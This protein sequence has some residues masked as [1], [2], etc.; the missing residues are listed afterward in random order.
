[1]KSK[2]GENPRLYDK[3]EMALLRSQKQ[4]QLSK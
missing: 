2:Y 4:Q 3:E 1:M